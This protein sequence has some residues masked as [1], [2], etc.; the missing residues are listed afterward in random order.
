MARTI[1]KNLRELVLDGNKLTGT[2]FDVSKKVSQSVKTNLFPFLDVSLDAIAKGCPSLLN[3]SIANCEGFSDKVFKALSKLP[4]SR[5]N[6][7]YCPNNPKFE[8]PSLQILFLVKTNVTLENAKSILKKSPLLHTLDLSGCQITDNAAELLP[9]LAKRK[10]SAI[11]A[12]ERVNFKL[13]EKIDKEVRPYIDSKVQI[14]LLSETIPSEDLQR[15]K[16][17]NFTVL[18]RDMSVRT[19]Q[20][21]Y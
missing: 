13:N 16:E 15:L 5:L 19:P 21:T 2:V 17:L 7:K 1:G 20:K 11:V 12:L 10:Q 8:I 6:M 14:S 9:I 4:L 3:L 18:R